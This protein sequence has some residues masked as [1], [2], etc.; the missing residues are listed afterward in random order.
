[1]RAEQE[2]FAQVRPP[3]FFQDVVSEFESAHVSG[4]RF[5]FVLTGV[6]ALIGAIAT[7]VMVRREDRAMRHRIF[8]RRSRWAWATTGVGPGLTREPIPRP[9]RT[10]PAPPAGGADARPLD[11]GGRH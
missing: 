3:G 1:M 6:I 7:F 10:A 11:E 8:S 2:G 9:P 4:Y 5:V